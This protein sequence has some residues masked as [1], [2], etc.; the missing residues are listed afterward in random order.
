[1]NESAG[2]V[3]LELILK[4]YDFQRELTNKVNEA[5]N[6]TNESL[7]NVVDASDGLT[8]SFKKLGT[9]IASAFA[10]KEMVEFARNCI[11]LG[12]DLT[13]VQNVVDVTFQDMTSQVNDWAKSAMNNFGLSETAAKKYASTFGAMSKS[14][15]FTTKE[16]AAMGETLTGLTADVASFYNLSTDLAYI[17]LKSVFT[18]ET[19]SLKDLGVVMTQSALDA[20]ALANGFGKTTSEMTE[21]EKVALRYAFVQDKLKDSAGDFQRTSSSW[22]NQ[23]KI[24]KQQIDAIKTSLGQMFIQVLTPVINALNSIL[25][26]IRKVVD[27]FASMLPAD[28]GNAFSGVSDALGQSEESSGQLTNN[29]SDST[30]AA[31]ELKRTLMGF[32]EINKL[33]DNSLL[34]NSGGSDLG[35]I[36]KIS[37][38]DNLNMNANIKTNAG[39]VS[40]LFDK[41]KQKVN[42]LKSA[43][44]KG[45]DMGFKDFDL[46]PIFD[47]ISRIKEALSN[48]FNNKDLQNAVNTYVMT[49]AETLGTLAG[50]FARMGASVAEWLTGGIAGWLEQDGEYIS[51]MLTS[52]FNVKTEGLQDVQAFATAIAD[53]V[54]DVLT[55]DSTVDEN[56]FYRTR[57]TFNYNGMRMVVP[58]LKDPV[59]FSRNYKSQNSSGG[60]Y[61][62][63]VIMRNFLSTINN[64]ATPITKTSEQTMKITY[65]ITQK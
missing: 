5:V 23:I 27:A 25:A 3:S 2:Q 32:D 36:P 45:W 63:P 54:E 64:L 10:I 21:A 13:E 41:L 39:E 37:G 22:A 43:F 16:A 52:I 15:G 58:D 48:I 55:F 30:A 33:A 57:T 47:N 50:S 46:S 6:K 7:G 29:I 9:T 12:S 56:K 11:E 8:G 20:F 26:K 1:M 59:V 24:L 38:L 44:K 53:I 18:G 17:K 34:N 42:E 60:Y 62:F 65:T 35:G 4:S 51:S 61:Y 14:F 19:E 40:E 49:F 31:K 28:D